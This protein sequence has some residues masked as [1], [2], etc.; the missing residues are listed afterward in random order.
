ML[1]EESKKRGKEAGRI[2]GIRAQHRARREKE[3]NAGESSARNDEEDG[4]KTTRQREA[5]KT[6]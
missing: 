3:E 1:Q 5:R 2:G 4:K 6:Y